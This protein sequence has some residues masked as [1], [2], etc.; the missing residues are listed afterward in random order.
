MRKHSTF[1]GLLLILACLALTNTKTFAQSSCESSIVSN[2]NGTSIP[3]GDWIWFSAV[4]KVS[5]VTTYPVHISFTNQTIT[6]S[7]FTLGGVWAGTGFVGRLIIDPSFTRD[8]TFFVSDPSHGYWWETHVRPSESGNYFVGGYNYQVPTTIPGGLNPV[9]WSGKWGAD[10]EGV[11]VN[12]QWAAAVYTN[13]SSDRNEINIKPSDCNSCSVY[14]NSDHAGTPEKY[15]SYVIGGARGG[16]G[17]NFTGSYSGTGSVATCFFNIVSCG[18]WLGLD[19]THYRLASSNNTGIN[20]ADVAE[21]ISV[22]PNPAKDNM[23]VVI[24]SVNGGNY[25]LVVVDMMGKIIKNENVVANPGLNSY[26]LNIANLPSGNYIISEQGV[27]G[28]QKTI[29]TIR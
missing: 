20:G 24:A 10:Q 11:K 2:F 22:F 16:G 27:N 12:W 25:N 15:K 17:S 6:S 26:Q 28:Y 8:T 29:V 14:M 1:K 21:S 13:F 5:N 18:C 19:G 7:Y 4:V 23:N 3:A 9:T